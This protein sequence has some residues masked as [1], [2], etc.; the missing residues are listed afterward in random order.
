MKSKFTFHFDGIDRIISAE[1]ETAKQAK[2]ICW[3]G[4]TDEERDGTASIE[5]IDV[6]ELEPI[7]C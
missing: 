1:A 6:E 4:L 2:Q 7:A 3:R 5:C